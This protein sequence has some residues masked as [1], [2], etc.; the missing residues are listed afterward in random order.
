MRKTRIHRRPP[1][2]VPALVLLAILVAIYI[3]VRS[4]ISDSDRAAAGP[5]PGTTI[6]VF[7]TSQLRGYRE[8]C[9]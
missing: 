3:P 2:I 8:P 6:S 5:R 9:G 4:R 1:L 7:F